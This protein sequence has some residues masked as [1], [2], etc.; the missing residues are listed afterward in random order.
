MDRPEPQPDDDA[1][2][3][4]IRRL[5]PEGPNGVS[6]ER[7]LAIASILAASGSAKALPRLGRLEVQSRLGGGGMGV[8]YRAYD[9]DLGRLVAVKLL[10]SWMAREQRSLIAAEARA[11]AQ[12]NHPNVVTV[13][14]IVE[15]ED[16]L[17]FVMEYVPGRTLR[18]WLDAHPSAS[19][20]DVAEWF[21]QA[22]RGLAAAH[23][24]GLV[25]G[26]FKPENVLVGDDGRVRVVDFGLSRPLHDDDARHT[27]GTPHY[28]APELTSRALPS[29]R[30]DQYAF[31]RALEDALATRSPPAALSESVSRGLRTDPEDRHPD[32]G[33]L[34]ALLQGV[35]EA[36]KER[37][38]AVLLT[39][40]DRLWF[41]GVLD[42]SL[43][44]VGALTI[45]LSN[46]PELVDSGKPASTPTT[47]ERDELGVERSFG[48]DDVAQRL[49]AA[50]GSLLLVGGPGA[51]KTTLL[52]QLGRELWRTATLSADA[53][54]P[55]VL[56]L[57]TYAPPALTSRATSSTA[58]GDHFA[59]WVVDELVAKYGLP[60]RASKAW[61]E[62]ASV[63][64]LLDGLDETDPTQRDRVIEALNGFRATHPA[65]LVVTSRDSE[66]ESATKRLSFGAALRLEPLDDANVTSLVESKRAS[67]L[68]AQLARDPQLREELR[69]PLLLTLYASSA[70]DAEVADPSWERAYQRY[71]E[72]AF[73]G[74]STDERRELTAQ[75]G[76]LAQTMRRL[77]VSDLWFERLT[78]AWLERPWERRVGYALGVLAVL[79][80]GVGLNLAQVPLT[81]DPLPSALT[82]GI[83]VSLSSFAFTRGRIKPV[84]RLR[85]SWRRMLRLLP[86]T[87]VCATLVGLAEGLRVNFAA[88]ITGAAI[89]G[90]ILAVTFALE[91]GD[92]AT[93][94]RPNAGVRRSLAYA[95]G[96]SLGFGIPVGLAFA[97]V[98]NPYVTRPLIEVVE[99]QGNPSLVIGVAVG[100][101]VFTALF[102]IYG[103]FTVLMHGVLR[104][105]LAW[106]TPLPFNLQ[107][108]LDRAVELRLM[109]RVG[110]GYLFLH[111]TL[112]DHFADLR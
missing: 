41:Q 34:L 6:I 59:A 75:L 98:I 54:A 73:T 44:E 1:L 111:R 31:C 48:S 102:L 65:P 69:N 63:A 43:S 97:F 46:A 90:A 26:D 38:R 109:R 20:R 30:R 3:T 45:A 91:A 110:G 84:E 76:F 28:M 101:F 32:L 79:L 50:H 100:L 64:L 19:W 24:K 52:L 87:T 2:E 80:F 67:R 49:E 18:A 7:R 58:L 17:Y 39:R 14:E 36:S 10:R 61:L 85:W 53:P 22:G 71:V 11:L 9:P 66:Y 55:V 25:H 12:L 13:H 94:V 15:G 37:S 77:S 4:S 68:M 105:W 60:R 106:R 8:V 92:R 107:R 51:G 81:G 96:V 104:L 78:F 62:E 70:D 88:N 35:L 47:W 29:P 40:I 5:R 95:L 42:R 103:G 16:E 99:H 33:E 108:A 82:F 112:L 27:G 86:V 56:S 23:D 93:R 57:S 72:R 21:A 83:G 89:T 74:V